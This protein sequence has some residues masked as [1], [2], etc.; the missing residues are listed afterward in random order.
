MVHLEVELDSRS[1]TPADAIRL[2][3][4]GDEIAVRGSGKSRRV[5]KHEIITLS[6]EFPKAQLT[7][8]KHRRVTSFQIP[9]HAPPSYRGHNASIRYALELH[10]DIP[11]WPDLRQRYELPVEPPIRAPQTSRPT[12]ICTSTAGP[13]RDKL[14]IEASL[15]STSLTPGGV[16]QGQCAL[17]NVR[18]ARLRG[19]D[20]ALVAVERAHRAHM[21]EGE[22][23]RHVVRI[24]EGPPGEGQ[25]LPFRLQAPADIPCSYVGELS[26]LAWYV[27]IIAAVAW[28][29]DVKMA[30]PIE[31]LPASGPG[32]TSK[33]GATRVAAVGRERRASVW[34][35]VAQ[36]RGL[37]FDAHR[38]RITA[39]VGEVSLDIGLE[40]R[41]AEGPFTTATLSWPSLGLSL[42]VDRRGLTDLLR[43]TIETGDPAFD[44]TLS[45][46][47]REPAQVLSFLGDDVRAAMLSFTHAR[48]DDHGALLA[49]R[50]AGQSPEL[51]DQHVALAMAAARAFGSALAEV[52]PPRAFSRFAPAWR[53]HAAR[54]KARFEPGRIWIHDADWSGEQMV[55]GTL[56]SDEGEVLGTRLHLR[57]NPS[58]PLDADVTGDPIALTPVMMALVDELHTLAESLYFDRSSIQLTLASATLDPIDLDPICERMAGFAA[59]IRGR[60][61]RGPYR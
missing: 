50:G 57:V 32:E 18:H 55:I 45:A 59:A 26:R 17:A 31:V 39:I 52:P 25:S 15:E 34:A 21:N 6:V 20:L 24:H 19:V 27:E 37:A 56:W 4:R 22:V 12:V 40:D 33:P 30:I 49:S 2:T 5:S 35:S 29:S 48:A 44:K 43:R 54:L 61:N 38:D 23:Q 7:P 60:E 46:R 47:G 14:Y 3:F 36:R 8:G 13:E 1:D 42:E 58:R 16:L 10:V 11:W 51:L 9:R 28:G 41:G 53:A